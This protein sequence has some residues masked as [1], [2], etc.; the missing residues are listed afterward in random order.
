MLPPMRRA[1]S[2]ALVVSCLALAV[3]LSGVGYAAKALPRNSIGTKQLKANAVTSAKIKN[4]TIVPADFKGGVVNAGTLDSLD[5]TA[6]LGVG[7]KAA[8]A[9][10]VDGVDSTGFLPAAGKAA[11][12]DKIDGIDSTGLMRGGGTVYSSA[13]ALFP[14]SV[15]PDAILF[16]PNV[17]DIYYT[18]PN[19]PPSSSA[20]TLWFVNSSPSVMTVFAD[21]GGA[22]PSHQDMAAGGQMLFAAAAAGDSFFIQAQGPWGI[23]SVQI[24]TVNRAANCH[25]QVLVVR[26]G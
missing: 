24:A 15:L 12:A 6:F 26:S 11:D 22:N 21:S 3:A 19:S 4:G 8:D 20:G 23:A 7:A 18:C 2:P 13:L 1:P 25:V 16:I 10:T 9:E 5:S 14:G 17:M